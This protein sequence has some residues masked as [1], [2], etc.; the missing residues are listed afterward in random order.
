MHILHVTPYYPPTWSYGGIPRIVDGLSRAQKKIG[1]QVSILT[2]DVL[3]Q[4]QR[5]QC[6]RWRE[7]H[8]IQILNL[9][10]L[11]N[12]LAYKQLFLPLHRG[13]LEKLPQPDIIHMHGHRH[14]LNNIAWHY[15]QQHQIPYLMTTNG[16]L[17]R[18]ERWIRLKA[19]WD[20]LFSQ[21]IIDHAQHFIAVSPM[22][23]HIHRQAGIPASKITHIPNGLDLEEFSPLPKQGRF[24]QQYNLDKRPIVAYL[25]QLSPRKGVLHLIAA[26]REMTDIQ[27]VI[28]GNDMGI[29]AEV[30]KQTQNL[31]HIVQTGLLSGEQRLA[32]LSD[33]AMLVYPSSN[34][35]FGLSP[36]EGLLCGAPAIVSN[37]CGCGQLIS[38]AQAGLLVRYGDIYDIQQK[39]RSL[40]HDQQ[41]AKIM[42]QR[43]RSYIQNHLSFTHIAKQHAELYNRIC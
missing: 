35:I 34:E 41:M 27:L 15:A 5:N 7:E 29:G 33:A 36:F 20:R 16:T 25:G 42:V 28:A 24:R 13:E 38:K 3:N 21:K 40:L 6:P 18:H 23:T 4:S 32:L 39:I 12:Q 43:G 30:K 31:N 26:C 19:I 14:L 17:K 37:D 11:S 9:P 1:L 2:T 10:N 8:G 22:D